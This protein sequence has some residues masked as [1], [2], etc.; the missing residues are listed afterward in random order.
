MAK[1]VVNGGNAKD[2]PAGIKTRGKRALYD[3]LEGNESLTDSVN[4]TII[5]YKKHGWAGHSIKEKQIINAI[6]SQV[7]DE[8]KA[9]EIMNLIK[10]HPE[11]TED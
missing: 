5:T 1:A 8:N 4:E 9:Q 7:Q 3:L 6:K 2:Y 10:K 11:Y